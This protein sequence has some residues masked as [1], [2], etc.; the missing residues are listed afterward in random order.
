M[1]IVVILLTVS[2]SGCFQSEDR[3]HLIGRQNGDTHVHEGAVLWNEAE[4]RL[5]IEV[6]PMEEDYA[7]FV[8]NEW[9][10]SQFESAMRDE[11]GFPASPALIDYEWTFEEIS[12]RIYLV[13]TVPWQ[14]TPTTVSFEEFFP[15]DEW[16]FTAGS[17]QS[18][19]FTPEVPHFVRT[20]EAPWGEL[21]LEIRDGV[22]SA[23]WKSQMQDGGMDPWVE[24]YLDRGL[25]AHYGIGD[26]LRISTDAEERIDIG[27]SPNTFGNE[28]IFFTH[29]GAPTYYIRAV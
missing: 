2:V 1:G 4:G 28:M 12:D 19:V 15:S 24:V 6:G 3:W 14:D 29:K 5:E 25:L 23:D 27:G 26:H 13:I 16:R 17:F 22:A 18:I 9:L 21:H 10:I 11:H 7:L 20:V 8:E